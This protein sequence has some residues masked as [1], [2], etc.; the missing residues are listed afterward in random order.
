MSILKTFTRPTTY[1]SQFS[2]LQWDI[3]PIILLFMVN[4]DTS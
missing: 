2:F 1:C 3:K 4:N